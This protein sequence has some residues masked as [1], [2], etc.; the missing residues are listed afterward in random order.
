MACRNTNLDDIPNDL[1]PRIT[2]LSV[3]GHSR[4][5]IVNH[6]QAYTRFSDFDRTD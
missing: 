1:D 3:T 5:Q 4:I 2:K 6:M